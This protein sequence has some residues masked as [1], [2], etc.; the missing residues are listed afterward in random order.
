MVTWLSGSRA[1]GL[2]FL[3]NSHLQ[4]IAQ[5]NAVVSH[6][7]SSIRFTWLCVSPSLFPSSFPSSSF[8]SPLKGGCKCGLVLWG[9]RPRGVYW[10]VQQNQ[11]DQITLHSSALNG[12]L[13]TITWNYLKSKT[14][15]YYLCRISPSTPVY[16][17]EKQH[18]MPVA[19]T[20]QPCFCWISQ[21]GTFSQIPTTLAIA[22]VIQSGGESVLRKET[23]IKVV[24]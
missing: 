8:N 16:D 1:W 17:L 5:F 11:C 4:L 20:T 10:E 23:Y 14:S 3:S 6:A 22:A 13:E 15:S 7:N 19:L 12:S 21:P 24:N 18:C 2:S 9:W